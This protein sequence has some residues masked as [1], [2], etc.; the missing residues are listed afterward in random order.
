V[1][2]PSASSATPT[3]DEIKACARQYGWLLSPDQLDELAAAI[4][5]L[6]GSY[7]RL[8][9]LHE[10]A[11]EDQ[12]TSVRDCGVAPDINDSQAWSWLCD[13]HEQDT[14]PLTGT[15]VAIKDSIA[16]AG[17][18]TMMGSELLNQPDT[19]HVARQ[20]A[21]VVRRLLGAGG[22]IRGKSTTED[23][24]IGGSSCTSKPHR[25]ENPHLAGRSAG[26]SSSGSAVLLAQHEVDLALGADQGGS[27][28][29][30]AALCA[31]VGL[32]PTFGSIPFTGVQGLVWS[33]DHVGPMAR[34]VREVA[35]ALDVLSGDDGI[36]RRSRGVAPTSALATLDQSVRGL[37]VGILQEGFD[38]T[39][40]GEAEFPGSVA[41]ADLVHQRALALAACGLD[42]IDVSLP[43]HADAQH[44][45]GP[46]LVE[47]AATNIW[48]SRG[49]ASA[50]LG[51]QGDTP[52]VSIDRA[53]RRYPELASDPTKLLAIA[54]TLFHDK[55]AG[56]SLEAATTQVLALRRIYDE[57]LNTVDVLVH[58]TTAPAGVS[59]F[60]PDSATGVISESLAY[61]ANT[62]P[63]NLTG[64]PAITVPVGTVNGAPVGM[65]ITG[66]HHDEA[67]L[68]RVALAVEEFVSR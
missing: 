45:Y 58:P 30:P 49:L 68:L 57:T 62:C 7:V 64:H 8:Q 33:M 47:S 16:V 67:T 52:V 38:L 3:H 48:G 14:G 17:L 41:A 12:P 5:G 26:G 32:K 37:R 11:H 55:H 31:L 15:S 63:T 4:T 43:M 9:Q 42:V 54:G 65:H 25:L 46:L 19:R 13:I 53:L 28:R 10:S 29:I 18:P 50:D 20:D 36:D 34:S 61:F 1:T 21:T 23:L 24:C 59:G 56:E 51:P 35:V 27:I 44:I 39:R 2:T 40:A 22:I 6:S 60:L 66:R